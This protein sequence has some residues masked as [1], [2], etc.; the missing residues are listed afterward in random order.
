MALV[1]K[2]LIQIMDNG[3]ATTGDNGYATGLKDSL[4]GIMDKREDVRALYFQI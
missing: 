4:K 3:E 2:R 1:D